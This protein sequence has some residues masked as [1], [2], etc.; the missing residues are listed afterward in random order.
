M[1]CF[2]SRRTSSRRRVTCVGGTDS[3][4]ST[5]SQTEEASRRW[6]L[7]GVSWK[8]SRS[9]RTSP[10][11]WWATS[12]TW[13]TCGRSPRRR[14][15]SWRQRWRAPSSSARPAPTRAAPWPRPSTSCAGRWGGVKPSRVRPDAAAPPRTSNRP[16]T[17]CWP[18][19]AAKGA[20]PLP[21]DSTLTCFYGES[22]QNTQDSFIE[23]LSFV[24]LTTAGHFT[25]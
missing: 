9:R 1:S 6:L 23:E 5:T 21:T 4:S 10:W 20:A 12:R 11:C 15:S 3:S 13:T 22:L 2:V 17:R 7:S 19:S 8:T 25:I 14:G 18:R 16:S 24:A